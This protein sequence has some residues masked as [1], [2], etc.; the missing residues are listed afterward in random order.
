MHSVLKH[1]EANLIMRTVGQS[2]DS[3][4][5]FAH[6]LKKYFFAN[7]LPVIDVLKR[8]GKTDVSLLIINARD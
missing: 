6:F 4:F 5:N 2:F 1:N 7:I 3:N 8:D